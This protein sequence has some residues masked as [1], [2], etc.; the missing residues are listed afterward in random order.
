[1]EQNTR[2]LFLSMTIEMVRM[3][4][5]IDGHGAASSRLLLPRV[6]RGL[7]EEHSFSLVREELGVAGVRETN[8]EFFSILLDFLECHLGKAGIAMLARKSLLHPR[9]WG[10]QGEFLPFGTQGLLRR[11]I[12]G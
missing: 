7:V 12:P 11:M 2:P 1:M 4:M 10:H 8:D 5:V 6:A 3:I 9:S